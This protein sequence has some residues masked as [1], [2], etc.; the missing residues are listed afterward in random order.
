[1][2]LRCLVIDD[3]P[4]AV[5]LLTVY[6]DK[7]PDLQLAGSFTDPIQ[8]LQYLREQAVD[9]IF[10]DVQMPELNG[11]QVARI[12]GDR[13]KIILTTAYE[14]YALKSYDLKVVDYLLKPITFARFVQAVE[15]LS[16]VSP[17]ISAPAAVPTTPD[18]IF[19][20]SGH[21][22]HRIALNDLRYGTT[23]GDYLTLFL[24]D[25]SKLL[26]LENIGD[27]VERLPV[28]RFCRIHRSHFVALDKIDF[29]ERRRVCISGEYLPISD[30]YAEAFGDKI[31]R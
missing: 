5:N 26:T 6:V 4:L 11:L 13:C 23:G 19:V 20:K 31:E 2:S 29:V 9:V 24:T 21:R 8:A 16:P 22:T 7:C 12:V 15:K 18:F 3:E 25:G 1:M 17:P 27:L 14:E 28:E 30:S 10:L